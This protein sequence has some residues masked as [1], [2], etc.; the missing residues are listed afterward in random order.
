MSSSFDGLN[1]VG[2][3]NRVD[4]RNLRLF[5]HLVYVL[6]CLVYIRVH[7]LGTCKNS[8]SS[9]FSI[10]NVDL[11]RNECGFQIRLV[12]LHLVDWIYI[13]FDRVEVSTL[14]ATRAVAMAKI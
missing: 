8:K 1:G 2:D 12:F 11:D 4:I 14:R 10:E 9:S 3:E 7:L 6:D 5:L 13:Q